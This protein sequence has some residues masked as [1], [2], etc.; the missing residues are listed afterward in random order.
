METLAAT[1]LGL[2]APYLAKGAE[3]FAKEAGKQAFDKIGAVVDRLRAW[4]SK[5][6]VAAALASELPASPEDNS[7]MLGERLARAM[8]RDPSLSSDLSRLVSESGPYVDV[9]QKIEIAKGVTGAKI[10][11]AIRG[12]LSVKQEMKNADSV[13]GVEIDKLG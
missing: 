3:E 2:I 12:T 1:V 4:W 7:K 13:T 9:V 6:P 11:E 5:D 10:K 8:E